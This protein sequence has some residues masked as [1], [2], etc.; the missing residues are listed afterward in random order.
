MKR[1]MIIGFIGIRGYCASD[2]DLIE[3][4]NEY[5]FAEWY[6][7]ANSDFDK[8]IMRVGK[9]FD[10]DL[11]SVCINPKPMP[12]SW[13][14]S[15]WKDE[16]IPFKSERLIK[17]SN[18]VV[19]LTDNKPRGLIGRTLRYAQ[20][21]NREV[22][23]L[24]PIIVNGAERQNNI[25]KARQRKAKLKEEE[26]KRKMINAIHDAVN[27]PRVKNPKAISFIGSKDSTI[28]PLYIKRIAKEFPKAK[29]YCESD[30]NSFC[31]QVIEVG[32]RLNREINVV[33]VNESEIPR[34]WNKLQSRCV[35]L[36]KN[37]DIL[38]ALWNRSEEGRVFFCI[39]IANNDG[40]EV[41]I[42]DSKALTLI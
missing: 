39:C 2:S 23:T 22:L 28:D 32:K 18:L 11:T 24:D 38:V 42:W 19:I 6:H 41:R 25:E 27:S 13:I 9:K 12:V 4:I 34:T 17:A 35:K 33:N 16:R 15:D 31:N 21:L 14:C 7:G 30:T 20:T 26:E 5:P 29:W 10:M 37:C 3:L 1:K 36:V 40:K 8:Q